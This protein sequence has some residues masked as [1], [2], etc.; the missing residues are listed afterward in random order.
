MY[1]GTLGAASNRAHWIVDLTA[2]DSDNDA[3]DWTA[4]DRIVLEVKR[5]DTKETVLSGSLANGKIVR[6]STTGTITWTFTPSDMSA[7]TP[8]S[9]D[10]GLAYRRTSD[11]VVVTEIIATLPIL[12]GVATIP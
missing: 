5:Q 8:G 11:G 7:L 10:L 3:F 1:T 4:T 12:E 9:Y 2:T 6:S